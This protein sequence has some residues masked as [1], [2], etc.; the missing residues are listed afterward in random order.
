MKFREILIEIDIP[1]LHLDFCIRWMWY[2]KFSYK[3]HWAYNYHNIEW[4][5]FDISLG[6]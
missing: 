3:K 4:L 2:W 5:C 1:I 6:D